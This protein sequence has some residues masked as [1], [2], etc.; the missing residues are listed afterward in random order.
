MV[1]V[2]FFHIITIFDFGI[3][4]F[5]LLKNKIKKIVTIK[6]NE[7]D[8][9]YKISKKGL[10]NTKKENY[11]NI[12]LKS[13]KKKKNSQ[14]KTINDSRIKIDSK[15][16]ENNQYKFENISKYIDE[17]I[18]GFS[19]NLAIQYDKRNYCEYYVSL[20]KTQHNLI[21]ALFN[22]NDFNSKI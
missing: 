22:N 3:K 6:K 13:L 7:K 17:E 15:N 9:T 14:M 2:I 18:N 11:I 4:E 10:L 21:C 20:I 1:V 12:T 19:Y 8:K 5:S 16:I